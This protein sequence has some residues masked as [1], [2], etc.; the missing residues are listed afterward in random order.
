MQFDGVLGELADPLMVMWMRL[1]QQVWDRLM[2]KYLQTPPDYVL[3][4]CSVKQGFG[5]YKTSI[6]A[7]VDIGELLHVASGP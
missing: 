1:D 2:H 4:N 5:H 7:G 6:Q 3:H